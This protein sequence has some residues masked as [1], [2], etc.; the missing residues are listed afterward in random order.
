MHLSMSGSRC[1][2][3][4]AGTYHLS[5]RQSLATGPGKGRCL[6]R[7]RAEVASSKANRPGHRSLPM[8]D[9]R[10]RRYTAGAHGIWKREALGWRKIRGLTLPDACRTDDKPC[11]Q[12]SSVSAPAARFRAK[13]GGRIRMQANQIRVQD[14]SCD[15]ELE[16]CLIPA[17][18]LVCRA[19]D[20]RAAYHQTRRATTSCPG[21]PTPHKRKGQHGVNRRR[22]G[23]LG[24][25]ERR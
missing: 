2:T 16:R 8:T 17:L 24:R 6:V 25:L 21:R 18:V 22:C 14:S 11:C 4:H 13:R 7:P 3:Q 9:R 10:R 19:G 23:W 15:Q 1:L 20:C 12:I 5:N